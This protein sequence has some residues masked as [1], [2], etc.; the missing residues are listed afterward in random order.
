MAADNISL[1]RFRLE[2]IPPS[3]RGMPQVQV[4]FDIDANGILNVTARD[5]A[6]G[7]EQKV[8]ITATTNLSKEEI[9]RKVRES[10]EHEAE[11]R[12]RR[13]LIEAR[14]NADSLAYQTEKTLN[15]LDGKIEASERDNIVQKIKSLREAAL[16]DDINQIK[17]HMEDTQNAFHAI[18]QQLYAQQNQNGSPSNQGGN[19]HSPTSNSD[20]GEVVEG[21]FREA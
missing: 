10:R 4:T 9:E 21:E 13:E 7:K 1:G 8:T 15:E 6:T 20:E 3:P 11:D 17:T 19:G 5:Q 12:Q 18:S 16:G 14:N 2:G